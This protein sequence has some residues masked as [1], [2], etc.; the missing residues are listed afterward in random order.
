M[1][2]IIHL[3]A[4][5][6]FTITTDPD[7][8]DRYTNMIKLL[9]STVTS[10]THFI[11]KAYDRTAYLVDTFGPRPYGSE[12]L[13]TALNYLKTELETIGFDEV[14]LEEIDNA[15]AWIRGE[16]SLT[17]LSIRP[18]PTNIPMAG[19]ARSVG[20]NITA[21]VIMV[22]SFDDLDKLKYRVAGKIV[23]FNPQWQSYSTMIKFMKDSASRAAKYD[24][25]G[26]IIR[27]LAPTSI[28][29]PHTGSLEYDNK[30]AKIP[31]AF[32]TLE[33]ADMFARMINRNQTITVNLYMEA[34]FEM[35]TQYNLIA[36]FKGTIYPDE[37]VL[38]TSHL[39][40][41]D[42]GPQMGTLD[43]AAGTMISLEALRI[44]YLKGYRPKR[45]I[46]LAIFC[47]DE[48]DY[49]SGAYAYI[50]QHKEEMNNH[51][52]AFQADEGG[53]KIWGYGYTGGIKGFIVA[54]NA[55]QI[56]LYPNLDIQKTILDEGILRDN[57]PFSQFIPVMR[58]LQGTDRDLYYSLAGTAADSVDK[59]NPNG[60]D[61]NVVGISC[62]VYL[63][64]DFPVRL[65]LE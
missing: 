40:S 33:D 28:E 62:M 35:T 43:S 58:N 61:S 34:K 37:I 60:M 5:I 41:Y 25:V 23:F 29:N 3:L 54:R 11:N 59:L 38:L 65:P 27:S 31:A 42:I 16:E 22:N 13:T 50:K 57:E 7:Y 20:G 10:D 24:A 51:I 2:Q 45:T 30:Y 49:D 19:I 52:V 36:N 55:L 4:I 64:A 6:T 21:N 18:T 53:D 63:L 9:N 46:R 1:A 26:C 12:R 17:L 44:L 47:G 48:Y 56:L 14:K 8:K 15:Q 32:I 39:D